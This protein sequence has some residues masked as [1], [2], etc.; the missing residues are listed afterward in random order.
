MAPNHVGIVHRMGRPRN[1]GP[2]PADF[3]ENLL[4][5]GDSSL[6]GALLALR[7]FGF[8]WL[9]GTLGYY[10]APDFQKSSILAARLY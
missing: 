8:L 1:E 9:L 5:H 2:C 6:G 4:S 7:L 3:G 10:L